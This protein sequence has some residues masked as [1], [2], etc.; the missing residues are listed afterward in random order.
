[1]QN[2][3]CPKCQ[4]TTVFMRNNG[5]DIGEPNGVWVVSTKQRRMSSVNSYVCTTCGY[6]EFYLT[7]P[8]V[9]AEISQFGRWTRV[10]PSA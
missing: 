6:T 1:M 2:G 3:T 7:D 10:N 8:Q 9:L 5:I 4:A